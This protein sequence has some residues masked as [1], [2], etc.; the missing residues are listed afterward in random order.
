MKKKNNKIIIIAEA[1]INHN[2]Q[3]RIAKKLVDKAS[4]AGANYI[5]FQTYNTDDLVLKKTKLTPYQKKN[6]KNNISQHLMLQKNQLSFKD[7]EIL[8]KYA[9]KKKIKFLSTAFDE[10][11]LELLKRFNLDYIKIPS[12]EITNYLLL[13]KISRSNKKI[14]LSTGMASIKE[15]KKALNILNKKK[16]DL[17]I[18]HCTSDYPA[19]LKDLNL[20]FIHKLKKFGFGIGYSDHSTSIITPSIAVG[21][22]CSVVENILHYQKN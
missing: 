2:G 20:N 7:H 6:L 9:K 15:I 4:E 22:G 19:R 14:L 11:S 17:I 13:R 12:G 16:K 8:F 10:K 5:K 3:I 18:L 1:G 21:L